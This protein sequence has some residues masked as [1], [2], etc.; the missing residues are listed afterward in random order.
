MA[1]DGRGLAVYARTDEAPVLHIQAVS[2]PTGP[3]ALPLLSQGHGAAEHLHPGAWP[4][5]PPLSWPVSM[6]TFSTNTGIILEMY[7]LF[8]MVFLTFSFY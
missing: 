1:A 4:P 5:A 3:T 7:F 2:Q 6:Q 8:P